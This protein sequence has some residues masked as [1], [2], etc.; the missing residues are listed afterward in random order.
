MKDS[1]DEE[2]LRHTWIEWHNKG[3]NP[4]REPYQKFIVLANKAAKLNS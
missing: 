3:G 1:R 4:I 2:E